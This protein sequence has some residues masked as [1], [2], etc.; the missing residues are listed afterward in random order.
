MK[1]KTVHLGSKQVQKQQSSSQLQQ[2]RQKKE[3]THLTPESALCRVVVVRRIRVGKC[4]RQ[5]QSIDRHSVHNHNIL[6]HTLHEREVTELSQHRKPILRGD[7]IRGE[8]GR[9]RPSIRGLQPRAFLGQ[10]YQ[11][12]DGGRA[13]DSHAL[14]GRPRG[15][16]MVHRPRIG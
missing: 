13:R 1:K 10:Q 9:R 11:V 5:R 15:E 4:L 12:G 8:Q 16:Q 14:H 6:Q 2:R 7:R 3:S